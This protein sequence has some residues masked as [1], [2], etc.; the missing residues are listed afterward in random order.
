MFLHKVMKEKLIEISCH[1]S[2]SDKMNL[3]K[4]ANQWRKLPNNHIL[5]ITFMGTHLVCQCSAQLRQR[6]NPLISW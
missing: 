2:S 5:P 4:K 6:Q 3:L 1:S